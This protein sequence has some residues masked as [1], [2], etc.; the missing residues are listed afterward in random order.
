MIDLNFWM[1]CPRLLNSNLNKVTEMNSKQLA[2]LKVLL[3]LNDIYHNSYSSIFYTV[4]KLHK[5]WTVSKFMSRCMI[6]H[7]GK[8]ITES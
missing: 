6:N 1:C 5:I 4:S 7:P 8:K 3:F 2:M